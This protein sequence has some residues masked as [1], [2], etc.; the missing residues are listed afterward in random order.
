[1]ARSFSGA[2]SQYLNG[3]D[4]AAVDITGDYMTL[5]CWILKA[6]AG[7][8]RWVLSK[9]S[10]N[11]NTGQFR[12]EC[13][14]G[15][16][17]MI[18]TGVT[19]N[20]VAGATTVPVLTWHHCAVVKDG[21]GTNSFRAY[22]DGKIDGHATSAGTIQ[23]SAHPFLIGTRN[24]DDV[25]FNG[26]L[27]HAAVWHAGLTPNEI[28]E[29]SRGMSPLLIRPQRLGGYWPLNE[30]GSARDVSAANTVTTMTGTLP[31]VPGPTIPE[32]AAEAPFFPPNLYAG[33]I[34]T[35]I[36]AV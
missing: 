5:A 26:Y 1:M 9:E 24:G 4:V 20:S 31:P 33:L 30:Y 22:L 32:R 12:M 7:G 10:F 21:T 14:S 8:N 19:S 2:A 11:A 3:G 6:V 18:S 34:M 25:P 15:V 35:P 13:G 23:N 27:A 16:G 29:L 36:E 17:G 28:L